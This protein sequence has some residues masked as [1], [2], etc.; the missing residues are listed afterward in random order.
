MEPRYQT[1]KTIYNI[2]KNEHHPLTYPLS[3]REII[4]RNLSG[5]DTIQQHLNQ[6]MEEELIVM[7]Q[8]DVKTI[9]ITQAGLNRFLV[10]EA[11]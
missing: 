8:L 3:L 11:V 6:L 5:W 7:K 10:E 9:S 4:V 1:L 2:V